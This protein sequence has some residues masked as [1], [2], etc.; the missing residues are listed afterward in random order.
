MTKADEITAS[1]DSSM[2]GYTVHVKMNMGGKTGEW[3][4]RG[5]MRRTGRPVPMADPRIFRRRLPVGLF[6]RP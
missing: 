1:L 3:G 4:L 2:Y 5:G 6:S